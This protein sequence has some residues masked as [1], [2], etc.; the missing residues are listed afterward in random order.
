MSDDSDQKKAID[1]AKEGSSFF[2]TGAG[3]TGKSYVI[4]GILE[5]LKGLGK[6]VA[7]TAMTGCAALLLGRGARTLHSWAGIG[8]GK[9]PVDVLVK[10]IR[11]SKSRKNWISMDTL[12]IDEVSMMLPELLDKMDELGRIL[13]KG[14]SD[15]PFGGLQLILVGDMNQLPPIC[16]GGEQKFVFES[17]AW[18]HHIQ[19]TIVLT[20]VH[21]Q[22]DTEFLKILS[23]AR[24]GHLS[25][26]SIRILET[27]RISPDF[28]KKK[29]KTILP[30]LLFT[31]RDDVETINSRY[32]LKC[33]GPDQVFQVFTESVGFISKQEEEYAIERLD[34][35][36]SYVTLLTL[37]KGAQVMLLTNKYSEQGLVNGSRGIIEGF[38]A[39]TRDPLVKFVN[40]KVLSISQNTWESEDIV[41]LKRSQ[42]PLRLA[43]AIT[44]HKAQ[45]ATLD[46]ALIEIG[47]NTFEYGQAYVAL[48]RV[49][50][51]EALYIWD[52]DPLAFKVHPK[53]KEFTL[54]LA[55]IDDIIP[56]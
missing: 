56:E 15:K 49:K 20:T 11:K 26:E 54:R 6:D 38:D 28:F 4:R 39:L 12:I 40:G 17:N 51:L 1:Y 42:I 48:S 45:G 2:L 50:S 43:Y 34:K 44:I 5:A 16:I 8:L 52:L 35:N 53:V 31:R 30:T 13:R 3:G 47:K 9:E 7:L 46:C 33:E 10:K 32:L 22:T 25:E 23:E 19:T 29:S 18:K 36:G 55:P 37:R 24:A 21:R 14:F 41:G 27:R